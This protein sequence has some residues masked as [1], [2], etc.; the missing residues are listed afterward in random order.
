MVA[1]ANAYQAQELTEDALID[2]GMSMLDVTGSNATLVFQVVGLEI[3]NLNISEGSYDTAAEA[4]IELAREQKE[5]NDNDGKDAAIAVME[6]IQAA[7]LARLSQPISVGGI[8]MTL[9]EWEELDEALD[10]PEELEAATNAIMAKENISREEA[11]QR[12]HNLQLLTSAAIK[13]ANGQPLSAEEQAVVDRAARDPEFRR[14][15]ESTRETVQN[16]T[17]SNQNELTGSQVV[18]RDINGIADDRAFVAAADRNSAVEQQD[19]VDMALELRSGG[20]VSM[21]A[22]V[23][24]ENM[25]DMAA[26]SPPAEEFNAV[27]QGQTDLA[28][29]DLS[30]EANFAPTF[31]GP[32]VG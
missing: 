21:A 4:I 17:S 28:Q 20:S 16:L 19:T 30:L 27:A 14:E 32:A 12:V 2:A 18:S 6:D 22:D 10:T 5:R 13:T 1:Q 8:E 7:E 31:S 29:T 26:Y 11:A 15:V 24:P 23:D 25:F 9:G 3:E